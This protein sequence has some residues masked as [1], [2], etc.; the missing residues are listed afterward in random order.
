MRTHLT[1]Y[2]KS[3]Y[4]A[5]DIPSRQEYVATDTIYADTPTIDCGHTRAQFY[6]ETDSQVY[7]VHG[8]KTDK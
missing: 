6:C 7:D 5:L 2:F 8:I 3:P 1:R 4:P